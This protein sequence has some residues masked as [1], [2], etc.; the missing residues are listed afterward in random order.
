MSTHKRH[1]IISHASS[2]LFCLVS[3]QIKY[4]E[5]TTGVPNILKFRINIYAMKYVLTNLFSVFN[6]MILLPTRVNQDFE[7]TSK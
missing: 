1:G 5:P 4:E 6:L 7:S 2:L 3:I